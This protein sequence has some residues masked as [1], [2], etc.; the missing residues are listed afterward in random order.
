M[1]SKK[2]WK[3]F[4]ARKRQWEIFI[5]NYPGGEEDLLKIGIRRNEYY[6]I[7]ID[8][9][10]GGIFMTLDQVKC[11]EVYRNSQFLK[12]ADTNPNIVLDLDE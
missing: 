5:S 2:N 6:V 11:L 4:K 1:L 8:I 10:D 9:L 7:I 12:I 3:A